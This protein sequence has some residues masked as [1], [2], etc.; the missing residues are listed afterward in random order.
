[1]VRE[2][3]KM[4]E[5]QEVTVIDIDPELY[6]ASRQHLPHMHAASITDERI[7][8]KFGEIRQLIQ[9]ESPG[10]D[11]IFADLPDATNHG[12]TRWL[13]T[14]EF[15]RD[16][17]AL[18]APRGVFTTQAGSA[19]HID[20]HF[21]SSVLRTLRSVFRHATPYSISVPSY[22]VPWG[23][24]VATDAEDP[25]GLDSRRVTTAL[26]TL[27]PARLRSYDAV[28]HQH[29]FHLPEALREAMD[30]PEDSVL[31]RLRSAKHPARAHSLDTLFPSQ[32]LA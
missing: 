15:Y 2:F 26:E 1:M 17:H 14:S 18:L 21:F 12:S 25:A 16:I 11:A 30:N 4:P 27:G 9:K 23:F 32:H 3:L 22:G 8:V 10:F 5:L 31:T 24:V 7:R 19:T 13:F 6:A 20:C 29:M 28:T